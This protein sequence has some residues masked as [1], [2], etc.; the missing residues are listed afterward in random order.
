M[1]ST[2]IKLFRFRYEFGT[3]TLIACSKN[4]NLID[5]SISFR[6]DG[7]SE[8]MRVP[9]GSFRPVDPDRDMLSDGSA[10]VRRGDSAVHQPRK[11]AE[12]GVRVRRAGRE[13]AVL[14]RPR[15]EGHS[16]TDFPDDRLLG[17][18]DADAAEHTDAGA[19][20]CLP[21]HGRRVAEGS[22]VLRQN[23]DHANAR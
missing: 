20:R 10:V 19:V 8:R 9:L 12:I 5:A 21:V 15:A 1:Q 18:A 22:P 16:H 3:F 14:G 4:N 11:L 7:L 6:F 2:I 23:S 17:A 13:A